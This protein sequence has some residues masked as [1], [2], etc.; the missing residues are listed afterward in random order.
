MKYQNGSQGGLAGFG[1][2]HDFMRIQ[3]I[4]ELWLGMGVEHSPFHAFA[5]YVN[6][7]ENG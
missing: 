7:E 2:N 3:L 1:A 5:I 6:L 4:R